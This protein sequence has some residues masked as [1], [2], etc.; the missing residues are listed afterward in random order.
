MVEHSR[1]GRELGASGPPVSAD[2]TNR[3]SSREVRPKNRTRVVRIMSPPT[4]PPCWG[5]AVA[6]PPT[7]HFTPQTSPRSATL[8]ADSQMEVFCDSDAGRSSNPPP[9]VPNLR[10][11]GTMHSVD[12]IDRRIHRQHSLI[13]RHRRLRRVRSSTSSLSRCHSTRCPNL[14]HQNCLDEENV[15]TLIRNRQQ[16]DTIVYAYSFDGDVIDRRPIPQPSSHVTSLRHI[17]SRTAADIIHGFHHPPLQDSENLIR[18]NDQ[19]LS[20]F[21][22]NRNHHDDDDGIGSRASPMRRRNR[23]LRH[24]PIFT[25]DSM[26]VEYHRSPPH[27]SL[28]SSPQGGATTTTCSGSVSPDVSPIVNLGENV[29]RLTTSPATPP[30]RRLDYDIDGHSVIHRAVM[31]SS[32]IATRSAIRLPST[33]SLKSQPGRKTKT[34][35]WFSDLKKRPQDISDDRKVVKSQVY[36]TTCQ[37][38]NKNSKNN[39]KQKEL[40]SMW[41][42]IF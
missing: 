31:T 22:F 12:D 2:A 32:R 39:K 38:L 8:S 29:T 16:P 15:D 27:N 1:A 36:K 24:R 23:L 13:R 33:S 6:P 11:F 41:L 40:T 30:Q 3:G 35:Q 14:C 42:I 7:P 26:T 28:S 21:H 18:H 9:L 5:Q 4:L 17:P 37:S 25:N 19:I 34:V 10:D 20:N